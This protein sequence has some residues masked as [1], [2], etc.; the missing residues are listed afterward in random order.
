[1]K[2]QPPEPRHPTLQGAFLGSV[3]YG[4]HREWCPG[5]HREPG[6]PWNV[7]SSSRGSVAP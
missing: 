6:Q 4:D 2:A 1:M 3:A 7:C 5:S